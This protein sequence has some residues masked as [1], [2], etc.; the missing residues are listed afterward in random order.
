MLVLP[1]CR[2]AP[3]A[4]PLLGERAIHIG[5]EYPLQSTVLGQRR[6]LSIYL[7]PSYTARRK[8]LPVLYLLDG[9]P[10]Q[11]FMP[12]AG[13]STLAYLSGQYREFIVVGI[14]SDDRRFEL[15]TPSENAFD[16]SQIPHNGGADD[17]RRFVLDEV[18][19]FV[20]SRYRTSGE[21]VLLGE[22]L[23]GLF[24]VDT[25]LRAPRSFDHYIAVSPSVWWRD[26]E[27]ARSA[28]A[29]FDSG[30]FAWPSSLYLTVGDEQDIG[31][32]L[33]PLVEALRRAEPKRFRWWFEPQPDEHHNTIYHP[34]TVRALRRILPR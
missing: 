28:A 34:A 8:P 11:D 19:P 10:A 26:G 2:R 24:V 3:T 27:L 18:K 22:S 4:E 31:R 30:D 20:E 14:Q 9:G 23:A 13:L 1:S 29:R 7:P 21:D 6:S 33:V 17:F 5:T 15:T 25:F 12:V 16:K 32:S